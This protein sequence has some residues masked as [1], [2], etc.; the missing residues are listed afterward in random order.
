MTRFT[1]AQDGQAPTPEQLEAQR[2][3]RASIEVA[4][5]YITDAAAPSREHSLALTKLEEAL[6]WAGKAIFAPPTTP[7]L[8]PVS[9]ADHLKR[10]RD[11]IDALMKETA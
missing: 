2:Q 5:A 9:A 4:A 1:I 8:N 10:M 7:P 11:D 6:M 3:V